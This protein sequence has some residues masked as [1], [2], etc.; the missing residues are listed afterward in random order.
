VA[1]RQVP[2]E[3]GDDAQMAVGAGR[4]VPAE[5][6]HRVLREREMSDWALIAI[7]GV[8]FL[9][10]GMAGV[11]L[12]AVMIQSGRIAEAEEREVVRRMVEE[13]RG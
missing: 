1:L 7:V 9:A 13:G 3:A 10:G 4:S 8:A 5:V 11:V 12:S 2:A 6:V